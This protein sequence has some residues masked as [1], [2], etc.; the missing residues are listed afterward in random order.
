MSRPCMD[1]WLDILMVENFITDYLSHRYVERNNEDGEVE[2]ATIECDLFDKYHTKNDR[3]EC[4]LT[5]KGRPYLK[6]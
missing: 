4:S 1:F 3:A 6:P 2:I 5:L